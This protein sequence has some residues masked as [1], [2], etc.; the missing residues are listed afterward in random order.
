AWDERLRRR[1][2]VKK[3]RLG[4][5]QHARERLLREARAVARLNHPAI[6]QVYDLVEAP[7]CDWIVM[8]LVEG[9][10]LA[11]R[12]AAEDRLAVLP[13]L[14]LG[15]DVAEGLAEAHAHG[16]LHRDLK[17]T[18]VMVTAAGRAKIL[19]FGIAKELGE[20]GEA[21]VPD[22]SLSATGLILGTCHAM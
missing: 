15:K 6:V 14:Q 11:E 3:V 12:I 20:E 7:G 13:V 22:P 18:N 10:T 1:I 2:A 8:E 9:R 21:A 19:D 4:A 16:V 5:V 17:T